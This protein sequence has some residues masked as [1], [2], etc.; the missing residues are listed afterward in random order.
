MSLNHGANAGRAPQSERGLDL[1]E[2]PPGAL[3]PLLEAERLPHGIWEP[4]AG[5]GAI[6]KV[7][8]DRGRAVI[9][10][11]IRDWGFPLHQRVDFLETTRAPVGTELIL[12]NPP[13]HLVTEFATHALKLCP[14]VILFTRLA[15]LE[16]EK[17]VPVLQ[18]AGLEHVYV[19]VNRI[20]MMHRAGWSGPKNSNSVAFCWCVW[21]REYT[22]D[23]A[24]RWLRYDNYDPLEDIR[25]SVTEGY[26]QV[27]KRV[28]AGGPGWP[29]DGA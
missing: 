5:K 24:L 26:S 11:D 29:K 3:L 12:T 18:G 21:R 8:R 19:F 14:R 13:F 28:A 6:V 22:G 20:P 9:A 17:R 15:F 27:R 25:A 10:S 4:A 7:L 2:T 1:Y 16:S 23:P